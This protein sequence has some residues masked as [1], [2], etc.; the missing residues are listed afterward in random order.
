MFR[1]RPLALG[2]LVA[3]GGCHAHKPGASSADSHAPG[4]TMATVAADCS[5]YPAGSA[6]VIRTFCDGPAVVK[7]SVGA[8]A[9]TLTGG[10]CSTTGNVF[11][12]NLGVASGPGLAGPKPD[13]IGLTANTANGP[14][15]NAVLSINAGGKGYAV[16]QNDGEVAANGGSFTGK[17][18][19]GE[20][21][22]GTFTC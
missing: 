6:G 10:S 11:T 20:T 21:I 14:F 12:L 1:F 9:Y 22:S 16:T 2:A 4:T 7:L 18:I 3:L 15:T 5:K 13:Y 17:A 19:T 8:A